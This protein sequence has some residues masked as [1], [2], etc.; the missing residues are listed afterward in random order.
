MEDWSYA[1]LYAFYSKTISQEIRDEIDKMPIPELHQAE[2]AIENFDIV[3]HSSSKEFIFLHYLKM[4]IK[5]Y[6][7][8][9][10]AFI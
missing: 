10:E 6:E 7:T 2:F 3:R 4:F 9:P 5:A 8:C 1:K